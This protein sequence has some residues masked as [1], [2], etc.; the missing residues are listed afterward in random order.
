MEK[1]VLKFEHVGLSYLLPNG[2]KRVV[3]QD[4][5]FDLSAGSFHYLSG[6]SGAGKSSLLKLMALSLRPNQGNIT[7]F[8]KDVKTLRRKDTFYLRQH[9]GIVY[10]DFR[11]LPQLTI[12]ENVALPLHL[13][14][15]RDS[16]IRKNVI[17]ILEWVGLGEHMDALPLTLSGGEQQRAAIARAVVTRPRLLL[18]DEPTGNVD[19]VMANKLIYLFEQLY[20]L[21]TTVVLATH[22]AQLLQSFPH[23]VL[24]LEGGHLQLHPAAQLFGAAS[25]KPHGYSSVSTGDS[26]SAV[27]A[28]SDVPHSS[29]AESLLQ[30]WQI[31]SKKT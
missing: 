22:S 21:G 26:A 2:Q 19:E 3:L 10:Q 12:F 25:E 31:F 30:K 29:H 9:I 8:D 15:T 24:R 16:I 20:K 6:N 27:A 1:S 18:A 17:E 4:I 13:T 7:I 11:L 14:R 28:I 5:N 23:P